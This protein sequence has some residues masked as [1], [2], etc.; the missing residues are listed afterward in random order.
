MEMYF[1]IGVPIHRMKNFGWKKQK[2]KKNIRGFS[3]FGIAI[4]DK[5]FTSGIVKTCIPL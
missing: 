2:Q 3:I 5:Q 1:T 4:P